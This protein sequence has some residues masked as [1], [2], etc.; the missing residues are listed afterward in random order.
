MYYIIIEKIE[1]GIYSGIIKEGMG[2]KFFD[3][4][5]NEL[6]LSNLKKG[7]IVKVYFD[8]EYSIKGLVKVEKVD[9]MFDDDESLS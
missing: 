5:L 3:K 9:E 2:I 1:N 7:D 4:N 8:F 6:I